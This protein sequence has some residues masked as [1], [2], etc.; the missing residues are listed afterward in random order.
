MQRAV[1]QLARGEWIRDPDMAA[2]DIV[3]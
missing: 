3:P 1:Y 2:A